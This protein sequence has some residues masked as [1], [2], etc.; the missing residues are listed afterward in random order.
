MISKIRWWSY[1]VQMPLIPGIAVVISPRA[2]MLLLPP[3]IFWVAA[4]CRKKSCP[5]QDKLSQIRFM[6]FAHFPKMLFSYPVIS[7]IYP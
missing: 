7:P 5:D 3:L 4:M 6:T 1:T 2:Q